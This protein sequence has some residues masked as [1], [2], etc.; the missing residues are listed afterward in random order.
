MVKPKSFTN[1]YI[2]IISLLLVHKFPPNTKTDFVIKKKKKA[3]TNLEM[4]GQKFLS[5][6]N[7][8]WDGWRC[9]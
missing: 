2:T 9:L 3:A 8:R 7:K 6:K 5:G 1:I 4:L